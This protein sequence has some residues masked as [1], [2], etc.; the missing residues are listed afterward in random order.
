M[1]LQKLVARLVY[2][3]VYMASFPGLMRSLLAVQNSHRRPGLVHH[4]ISAAAYVTTILLR[5]NDVIGCAS[6]VFYVEEA[7]GD[8]TSVTVHVQA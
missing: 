6:A 4:M 5:I 8:H 2:R 3:Y 7:P 1:V